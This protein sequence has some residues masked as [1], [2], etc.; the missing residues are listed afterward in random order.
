MTLMRGTNG[1]LRRFTQTMRNPAKTLI[2]PE[3]YMRDGR[4]IRSLAD[5]IALLREH[6]ARPG[7]DVRDEVLHRLERARSEEERRDAADAFVAWA[8]ELDL[9][10]AR[11]KPPIRRPERNPIAALFGQ[12]RR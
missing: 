2:Q 5:A 10:L 4:I 9:L 12:R 8:E 1:R 6:E 7:V 11:P 3:L